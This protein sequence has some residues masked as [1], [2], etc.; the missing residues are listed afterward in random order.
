V[1]YVARE[2]G[3]RVIEMRLATLVLRTRD[4]ARM[5]SFY[6][7]VLGFTMNDRV[8]DER[9]R[10]GITWAELEAPARDAREP[11]VEL[12][13][14]AT[15]TLPPASSDGSASRAIIA[16]RVDD[17]R[18]AVAYLGRSKVG[19]PL[20]IVEESWGWF[21]YFTDP[22]GND[23]E[24]FQYRDADPWGPRDGDG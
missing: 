13:D 3:V 12:L 6:E 10:P 8:G 7:D 22:D 16:F 19:G 14:E 2:G 23:L 1:P 18:R 9:Y 21:C 24:V 15:H 5:R 4:V 20:E 11:D 17:I